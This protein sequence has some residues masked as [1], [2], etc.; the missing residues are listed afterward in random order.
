MQID[1]EKL[2][3]QLKTLTGN[4]FIEAEKEERIA[5]NVMPMISFSPGFQIRLAA[6]ALKTNPRELQNLPIAK[7]A[8]LASAVSNFLFS[9]DDSTEMDEKNHETPSEK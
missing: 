6:K 1:F 8:R 9:D 7:F 4:D 3:E 5:G 2:P